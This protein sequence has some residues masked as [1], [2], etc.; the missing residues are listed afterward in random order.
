MQTPFFKTLGLDLSR[1]FSGTLNVSIAPMRYR[2]A[3]PHHTFR[4]VRWHPT[5]PAEDFSFID[6]RLLPAQGAMLRGWIYYP[7]PETKPEHFQQVD[8]LE[9]LLPRIENIDV[10]AQI[11]LCAP[12]DQILFHATRD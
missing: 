4:Q 10:G 9:C 11:Q 7:H 1:Y 3:Q 8:V 12:S 5:Q 2:I 6:V